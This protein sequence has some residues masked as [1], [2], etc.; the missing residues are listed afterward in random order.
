MCSCHRFLPTFAGRFYGLSPVFTV[1]SGPKITDISVTSRPIDGTDTFKRDDRIE[2]TVTYDEPVEARDTS[3]GINRLYVLVSTGG[4]TVFDVLY[5]RQDHPRKLIFSRVVESTH[6]DD[7]GFCIGAF[8]QDDDI[9]WT[10]DADIVATSD[11]ASASLS[12]TAKQ[13]SFNIDG[14]TEAVTGGVCDVAPGSR[15][16]R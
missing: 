3:G 10:G 8:C 7:D 16:R 12:F 2:I 9:I 14:S 1:S 11:D 6:S 13:T 5:D 15:T 4:A